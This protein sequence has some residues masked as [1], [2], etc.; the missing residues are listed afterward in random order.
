[1]GTSFT[2]ENNVTTTFSAVSSTNWYISDDC[3]KIITDSNVYAAPSVSGTFASVGTVAGWLSYDS[4]FNYV[5]TANGIRKY[6]STS[7]TYTN[8][9]SFSA[10][11]FSSGAILTAYGNN[12][13]AYQTTSTTAKLLVV[14]DNGGIVTNILERSFT[15]TSAAA[16]LTSSRKSKILVHGLSSGSLSTY[17][18]H[19]DYS[20]ASSTVLTFPTTAVVDPATIMLLLEDEWLY[21]RQLANGV[22]AAGSNE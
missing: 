10:I 15:F 2:S 7:N 17:F 6:S 22:Q 12:L 3:L 5:L 21:L 9:Y 16:V 11:T 19:I 8:L 20:S 4:S 18:Y 1:M 13:V 14:V